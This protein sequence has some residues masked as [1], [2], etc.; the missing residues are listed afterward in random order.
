MIRHANVVSSVLFVVVIIV[1]VYG[2][3]LLPSSK[4][5][6]T[7]EQICSNIRNNAR[8]IRDPVYINLYF[9]CENKKPVSY[10]CLANF[11]FFEFLEQCIPNNTLPSFT[12]KPPGTIDVG[13][14]TAHP[15]RPCGND[16][17]LPPPGD[18]GGA[19]DGDAGGDDGGSGDGKDTTTTTTTTTQK[20]TTTTVNPLYECPPNVTRRVNIPHP[21]GCRKYQVCENGQ[22]T[23][24][25]CPE[26]RIYDIPRRICNKEG[27]DVSCPNKDPC[28]DDDSTF[29]MRGLDG[30]ADDVCASVN[31]NGQ[32]HNI[33]FQ[34]HFRDMYAVCMKD[35]SAVKFCP[36]DFYFLP[37]VEFCVPMPTKL[38]YN[39]NIVRDNGDIV[40]NRCRYCDR[41]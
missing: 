14:K 5:E 36:D 29:S 24:A 38:K 11:Y 37:D 23:I 13:F 40:G 6:G 1:T 30:K 28:D 27:G 33:Q 25:F 26:G 19:G 21:C 2:D 22:K 35:S 3:S 12:N 9:R 4:I 20:T 15:C 16:N 41:L 10:Q 8:N 7:A 34:T 31:A 39:G 32:P 17:P 18:D